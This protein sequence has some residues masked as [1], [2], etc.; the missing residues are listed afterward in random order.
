MLST[1]VI[2]ANIDEIFK[3][4]KIQMNKSLTSSLHFLSSTSYLYPNYTF[5]VKSIAYP[6][7]QHFSRHEI[8]C[9][10]P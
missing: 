1:S 8:Q 10:H 2:W 3:L 9:F 4:N 7:F 6:L 5:G